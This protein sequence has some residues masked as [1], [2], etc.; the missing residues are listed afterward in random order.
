MT[1]KEGK[2]DPQARRQIGGLGEP[3]A[4]SFRTAWWPPSHL[5]SHSFHQQEC[6]WTNAEPTQGFPES[7][8]PKAPSYPHTFL[9]GEVSLTRGQAAQPVS[10][11]LQAPG[12]GLLLNRA[13]PPP[14]GLPPSQAELALSGSW[15]GAALLVPRKAVETKSWQLNR[16]SPRGRLPHPP[17]PTQI[18]A[19]WNHHEISPRRLPTE[20]HGFR[21]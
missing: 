10:G 17:W 18:P 1:H 9:G 6:S 19:P 13:A 5:F 8:H 7:I 2:A 3:W 12:G 21:S 14:E 20:P 11:D 4:S 16:P 15:W